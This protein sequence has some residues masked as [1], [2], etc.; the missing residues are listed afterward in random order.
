MATEEITIAAEVQ[1]TKE[2]KKDVMFR[3]HVSVGTLMYFRPWP[4]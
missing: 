2:S 3:C 4:R 1:R